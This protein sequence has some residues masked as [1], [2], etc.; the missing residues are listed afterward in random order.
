M[1]IT[2][3]SQEFTSPEEQEQEEQ[4]RVLNPPPTPPPPAPPQSLTGSV[5]EYK[6]GHSRC[7]RQLVK[8][9]AS[10]A[11][12]MGTALFCAYMLATHAPADTA[13]YLALLSTITAVWVPTPTAA[14]A[15][16]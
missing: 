13:Q 16:E 15:G 5:R 9:S 12:S 7:S 8:Y 14:Q 3:R 11:M 1:P 2:T 10:L 6:C 4:K